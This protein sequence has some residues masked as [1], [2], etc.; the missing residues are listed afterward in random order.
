[1]VGANETASSPALHNTIDGLA[2]YLQS[3]GYSHAD[4]VRAAALQVYEQLTAQTRFLAF[5]DCFHILGWFTL[6]AAPLVLLT[7][8]FKAGGKAPAAH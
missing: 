6:A 5:M 2:G 1:V 7:Q 4:A 3:H 8:H